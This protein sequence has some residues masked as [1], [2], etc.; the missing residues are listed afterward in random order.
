MTVGEFKQLLQGV[1]DDLG[2]DARREQYRGGVLAGSRREA[3]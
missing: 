3:V 1:R 2:S